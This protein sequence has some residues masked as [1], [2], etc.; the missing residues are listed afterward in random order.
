LGEAFYAVVAVQVGGG[1][2]EYE[3]FLARR[4]SGHASRQRESTY[5]EGDALHANSSPYLALQ[6][7]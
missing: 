4:G 6:R 3:R 2:L 1:H 5:R 7:G